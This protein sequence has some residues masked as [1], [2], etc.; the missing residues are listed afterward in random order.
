VGAKKARTWVVQVEDL[1]YNLSTRKQALKNA[2]EQ[3]SRILDV[4]QKYAVHFGAKGVGF[5]CKKV[6]D[7]ASMPS[8]SLFL[9]HADRSCT[10]A[11]LV[12]SSIARPRAV[13]TQHRARHSWTRFAQSTAASL[14]VS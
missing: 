3:Y 6:R 2:S 9:G 13:S 11:L 7:L 10:C 14:Q 1:F 12:S 8:D 4:V 5:V